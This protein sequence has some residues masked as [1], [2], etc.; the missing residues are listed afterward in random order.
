MWFVFGAILSR[1]LAD[2][3][4]REPVID[5]PTTAADVMA[6]VGTMSERQV[7]VGDSGQEDTAAYND[8]PDGQVAESRPEGDSDS[9]IQV[10]PPTY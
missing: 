4:P 3:E 7:A 6:V 10:R 1:S 2:H 9:P 5:Q 8:N